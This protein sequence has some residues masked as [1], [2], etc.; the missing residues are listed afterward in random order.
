M[1]KSL[2]IKGKEWKIKKRKILKDDDGNPCKGLC[3]HE[4]RILYLRTDSLK[5]DTLFHEV[6]HAILFELH[7]DMDGT[8]N[9]VIVDG[10]ST[11]IFE[12]FQV[13]LKS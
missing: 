5:D 10:L 8:L 1:A 9:E 3:D 12:L 13:K 4:K 2:N 6:L 11:V 7:I